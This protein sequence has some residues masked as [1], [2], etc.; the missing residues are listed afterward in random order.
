MANLTTLSTLSIISVGARTPLGLNAAASAAAYRAGLSGHG[1]HPVFVDKTGDAIRTVRDGLLDPIL[2]SDERMVAMAS[3]A[4]EEA[5]A[6]LFERGKP[7][8]ALYLAT[9]EP[10][11]GWD[12]SDGLRLTRAVRRSA[13]RFVDVRSAHS[14]PRGHAAGLLALEYAQRELESGQV[15]AVLVGGVD[16]YLDG[17]TI[18]W[19]DERRELAS[20]TNIGGFCPGE[21][22]SFVVVTTPTIARASGVRGVSEVLAVASAVEV[23]TIDSDSVCVGEALSQVVQTASSVFAASGLPA[24]AMYCDINGQ[25]YRNE[26]LMYLATR[27][28]AGHIDDV[29][30]YAMPASSFGDIGAASGPLALVL[31]HQSAARGYAAGPH[32]MVWGSSIGGTRVAAALRLGGT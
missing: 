3:T 11:P 30:N 17:V 15:A 9:P 20:S 21:A 10:R 2:A 4:I 31:A 23:H 13:E 19:L 24:S 12:E 25:R 29:T 32:C 6:P 7:P 1:L 16:S 5:C 28:P 14:L 27:L 26:E 8:V 18:E 22:A